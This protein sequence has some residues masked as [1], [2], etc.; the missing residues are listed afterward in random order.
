MSASI[1]CQCF[2]VATWRRSCGQKPKR[3][4]DR[5]RN[6]M[7]LIE[8][9]ERNGDVSFSVKMFVGENRLFQ[10]FHS[11]L[12]AIRTL[13]GDDLEDRTATAIVAA[14]R[15]HAVDQCRTVQ[16]ID[17]N[18]SERECCPIMMSISPR[19]VVQQSID[20]FLVPRF[21]HHSVC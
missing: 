13:R 20:F 5:C 10:R 9:F 19:M 21:C 18:A 17:N 14:F 12:S 4:E 16:T 15:G 11:G 8:G 1:G 3:S 2:R 7:S 6:R